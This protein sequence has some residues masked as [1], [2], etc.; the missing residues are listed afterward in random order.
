[1]AIAFLYKIVYTRISNFSPN[2]GR[3]YTYM[4]YGN[5]GGY[6]K[7]RGGGFGRKRDERRDG[8]SRGGFNRGPKQMHDA[9]CATCGKHCQVPF[10]PTGAKPVHCSDCFGKSGGGGDR[11]DRAPRGGGFKKEFRAPKPDARIDALQAEVK[12]LHQKLDR[13]IAVIDPDPEP[14]PKPVKPKKPPRIIPLKTDAVADL[15][16]AKKEMDNDD[17][18][19]D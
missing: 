10:K 7:G 2:N 19:L 14:V 8:G 12:E 4:A 6:S 13:V 1:M 9:T 3:Q 5:K 15:M 17:I 18:I 16:E 11:R